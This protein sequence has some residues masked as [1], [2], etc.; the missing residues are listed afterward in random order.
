MFSTLPAFPQACIRPKFT[1]RFTQII[2][3]F[4]TI[5][6]IGD[7]Q[8]HCSVPEYCLDASVQHECEVLASAFLR[9]SISNGSTV[10]PQVSY[11]SGQALVQPP[12]VFPN[13][14]PFYTDLTSSSPRIIS[15]IS[16][17]VQSSINGYTIQCE[18]F[19]G[20]MKNCTINIAGESSTSALIILY[21]AVE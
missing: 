14:P 17:T 8:F 3:H 12:V 13:N 16:F 7:V 20:N 15:N 4:Y 9:W 11:T 19:E 1:C 10:G 6:V 2:L 18:D 21:T 5:G